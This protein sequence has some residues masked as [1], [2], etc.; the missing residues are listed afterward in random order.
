MA[1]FDIESMTVPLDH[2]PPNK[3]L[4]AAE[5]DIMAR[6]QFDMGIQKPIIKKSKV[7]LL[8]LSQNRFKTP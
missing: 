6:G 5:I 4:P 7:I 3:I 8:L 2:N 1:A